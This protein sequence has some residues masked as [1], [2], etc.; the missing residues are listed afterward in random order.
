M[1]ENETMERGT[2]AGEDPIGHRPGMPQD[3]GMPTTTEGL[4]P[5]SRAVEQLGS[6]R[7][8]WLSTADKNGKPHSAPVW[9][10]WL[11]GVLYFDGHPR[12]RWGR[13]LSSNPQLSVHLESG[14]HVVILEGKITPVMTME[15]EWAERIATAYCAKYEVT[16]PSAD[17]LE[18]RGMWLFKPSAALAWD[19]F[20]ATV[21][22]WTFD[23]SA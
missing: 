13:N 4:L 17:D 21:T 10:L 7:I 18:T 19:E 20:P 15:R 5:W 16:F 11:D 23:T 6:A 1:P 12:T 22:K 3:Y 8:Y 14:D 2:E 9:G